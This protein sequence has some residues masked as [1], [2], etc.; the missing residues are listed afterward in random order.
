MSREEILLK[1]DDLIVSKTDT[2]SRII[3]ANR[4]FC[5]YSGYTESE[6]IG[7]PQNIVRH[8]DMPRALFELM[9]SHL[10][11][12]HEF[13]GYIK[14]RSRLGGYYW[15]FAS[16]A[17]VYTNGTHSGYISARRCPSRQA[18]ALVEPI[19]RT[20]CEIESSLPRES[21]T[22]QSSAVLWR[23]INKEYSSYAEFILSL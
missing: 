2:N 12:E 1:P 15:T 21:Q 10:K 11:Q 9:W 5:H 16:V 22:A 7:K 13:F 14:N 6:L 4:E 19:Y 18:I 8:P 20:M 23:A 17:P 3:Y